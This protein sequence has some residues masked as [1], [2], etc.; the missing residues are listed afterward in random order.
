[1][2]AG[3]DLLHGRIPDHGH[4]IHIFSVDSRLFKTY[5]EQGIHTPDDQGIELSQTFRFAGRK[6][7]PAHHVFAEA[8]L[9]I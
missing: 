6:C 4:L 8:L 5:T 2:K 7:D 1:M 3:K 9:G